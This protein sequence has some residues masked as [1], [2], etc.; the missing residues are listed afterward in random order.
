MP[1]LALIPTFVRELMVPRSLP[2]EPEPALVMEEAEQ[3]AAY[4]EAGRIYGDMSPA[5]TMP[6]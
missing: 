2:R 6:T 5:S 4:V 1:N 3:L